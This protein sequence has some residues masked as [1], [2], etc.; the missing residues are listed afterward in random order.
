MCLWGGGGNAWGEKGWVT[1]LTAHR[2]MGPDACRASTD[3]PTGQVT[4]S[5][6]FG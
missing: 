6:D 3:D 4:R 5:R 2:G 1:D